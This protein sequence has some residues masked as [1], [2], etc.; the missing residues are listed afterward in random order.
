MNARKSPPRGGLPFDRRLRLAD[1]E[2]LPLLLTQLLHL[3]AEIVELGLVGGVQLLVFGVHLG[4]PLVVLA[5]R[6]MRIVRRG[7]RRA[8]RRRRG[9]NGRDGLRH[10]KGGKGRDR[11][12]EE[13]CTH[14]HG[15]SPSLLSSVIR[16]G[17][18]KCAHGRYYK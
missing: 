15:G 17:I 5:A 4:A 7:A 6:V 13:E 14:T 10:R 9:G 12:G 8:G 18:G 16:A 3:L 1:A 11:G 2:D